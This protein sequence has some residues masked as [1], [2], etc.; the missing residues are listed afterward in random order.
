MYTFKDSSECKIDVKGRLL[1][2]SI[3]RKGLGDEADRGFF[4]KRSLYKNC[5]E[6]FTDQRWSKELSKFDEIDIYNEEETDVLRSLQHLGQTV[7]LDAVGRLQIPKEMIEFARLES[8]V[9]LVGMIHFL[10]I[11]DKKL[12][13]ENMSLNREKLRANIRDVMT[14]INAK[15]E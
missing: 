10:E 5:L 7:Q 13:N 6:L 3:Y 8:D 15:K 4:L 9:I 11:W 2:P 14:R 1:L 12:F